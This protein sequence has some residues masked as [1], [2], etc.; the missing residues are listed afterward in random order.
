MKVH[1]VIIWLI[2]YIVFY[3]AAPHPRTQQFYLTGEGGTLPTLFLAVSQAR[4][5]RKSSSLS[6]FYKFYLDFKLLQLG[7]WVS[8]LSPRQKEKSIFAIYFILIRATKMPKYLPMDRPS[9][10]DQG[11]CRSKAVMLYLTAEG[12]SSV[13]SNPKNCSIQDFVI[14]SHGKTENFA[15]RPT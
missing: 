3:M 9:T 2:L 12:Q 6:E 14:D 5:P 1:L 8:C 10:N 11:R 13:S 15:I 4:I 7:D